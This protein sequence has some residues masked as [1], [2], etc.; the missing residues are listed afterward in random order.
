[1]PLYVN[2]AEFLLD[3]TSSDFASSH[4]EVQQH[5][6]KIHTDWEESQEAA[7]IIA[8]IA[9]EV[10]ETKDISAHWSPSTGHA[11]VGLF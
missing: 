4:E 2:P 8:A 9:D 3:A 5:L 10:E 6:D 1:M 11:S 7:A